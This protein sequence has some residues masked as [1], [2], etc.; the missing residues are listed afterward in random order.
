MFVRGVVLVLVIAA[1]TASEVLVGAHYFGGWYSC[2]GSSPNKCFSH[3]KGF[4]PTGIAVPDWR[5]SFPGRIPLLGNST[6]AEATIVA[7]VQAADRYG[8][9]YFD[10]LWYDG[11][12]SS[13]TGMTGAFVRPPPIHAANMMPDRSRYSV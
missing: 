8:L 3:W 9:D 5:P 2:N 10:V 13:S 6:T 11:G 1:A 7:E 4:T 12:A